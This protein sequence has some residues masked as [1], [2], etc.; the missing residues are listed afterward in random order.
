M[1]YKDYYEILGVDKKASEAEIKSKYRKLA[2]KYHPDLNPDD[3]E[4]EKKFKEISEAYEVLGDEEKRKQYDQ[5][6]AYGF[7]GGQNFNPNDFGYTYTSTNMGDFSDFFDLFFGGGDS[8]SGR[9]TTSRAGFGF[10]DIFGGAKR[11]KKRAQYNSNLSISLEEAYKGTEKHVSLSIDGQAINAD[12]KV[13]KGITSG[14]KLR[15]KGEKW[16]VDGDILFDI[17]VNSKED[18]YLEDLDIIKKAKVYPWDAFFGGETI[19]SPVSGKIKVT[20]PENV[21]SGYRV[22]VPKRGFEDLKGNKGDLLVEF[23]IVNPKELNQ[24]QK[25]YYEKLKESFN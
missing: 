3:Q 11:K 17:R 1:E 13:P 20:I 6:G 9:K 22:R 21:E 10:E 16:G 8:N 5:F 14:K 2:K 18:E 19:I 4:A 23:E 7:Q 25:K 15:T 24:K 12:V